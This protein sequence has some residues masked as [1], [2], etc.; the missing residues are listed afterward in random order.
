[1]AKAENNQTIDIVAEDILKLILENGGVSRVNALGIL[2]IT[3]AQFKHGLKRLR[4]KG[5]AVPYSRRKDKYFIRMASG[6]GALEQEVIS[7]MDRL[8][9]TEDEVEMILKNLR[10][11]DSH[12]YVPVDLNMDITELRFGVFSDLHLGHKCSRV[13]VFKYMVD[14]FRK[15]DIDIV[16]NAGDTL[17]GLSNRNGHQFELVNEGRGISAQKIMMGELFEQFVD[18]GMT[19][20][21]IEAES[22]HS[23]WGLRIGNQGQD[24]GPELEM[25]SKAYRF[26]GYLAQDFITKDGVRIR[27]HHPG[28]G[29]A[30]AL[31]YKTQGYVN[32]LTS[33]HKPNVVIEGHYH[34]QFSFQWRN[35]HCIGAGCLE[36]QTP[37]MGSKN[38]AAHVGYHT[39]DFEVNG[40]TIESILPRWK[41]FYD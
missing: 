2:G 26:L 40:S 16:L 37:F 22:S 24:I 13:D 7:E 21:S 35:V 11:R 10:G 14:D 15:R 38:I 33:G 23:S 36:D 34:K 25:Y 20:Y 3:D 18:Y 17:E 32:S 41:A 27:L 5:Y 28:G 29:T 1:M 39:I 30:Y 31:S 12:S 6:I 9:I 19:C 8:N 4:A